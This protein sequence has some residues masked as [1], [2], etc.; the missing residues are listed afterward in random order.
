MRRTGVRNNVPEP[1]ETGF[2]PGETLKATHRTTGNEITGVYGGLSKSGL[3][4]KIGEKYVNKNE[5][6][7][8]S[9]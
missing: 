7:I 1:D 9:L 2:R 6:Q 4:L 8:I 5:Y 3:S